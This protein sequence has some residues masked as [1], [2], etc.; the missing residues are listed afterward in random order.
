MTIEELKADPAKSWPWGDLSPEILALVEA[1][2]EMRLLDCRCVGPC[3]CFTPFMRCRIDANKSA[4][5]A[6]NVKLAS[7]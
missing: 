1:A 5:H 2:S 4:V 6:F 3:D 7:L